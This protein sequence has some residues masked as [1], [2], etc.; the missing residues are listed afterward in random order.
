[1]IHVNKK[2]LDGGSCNFCK[3]GE[4][5]AEGLIFT[6]EYVYEITGG[7]NLAIRICQECFDDLKGFNNIKIDTEKIMKQWDAM[8]KRIAE[9]DKSSAPSDWFGSVIDTFLEQIAQRSER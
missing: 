5:S 1:M 8:R 2:T 7:S 6:Y 3:R 4:V 9:G